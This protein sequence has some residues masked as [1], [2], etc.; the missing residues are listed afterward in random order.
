MYLRLLGRTPYHGVSWITTSRLNYF[1]LFLRL[2]LVPV[3][4]FKNSNAPLLLVEFRELFYATF[5]SAT[6]AVGNQGFLTKETTF[7]KGKGK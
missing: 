6:I 7:L 1:C 3:L 2:P 5:N 4:S